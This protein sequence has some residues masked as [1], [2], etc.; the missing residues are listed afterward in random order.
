MATAFT[1][2]RLDSYKGDAPGDVSGQQK[3]AA[4]DPSAKFVPPSLDSYKGDAPEDKTARSHVSA[5]VEGL[6]TAPILPQNWGGVGKGLLE[7]IQHP[8]DTAFQGH[9]Q[10][11]DRSLKAFK[12]GDPVQGVFHEGLS[13]I[14]YI[15]PVIDQYY[16]EAKDA[17]AKGDT[18][19]E[20]RA[21]GKIVGLGTSGELARRA[22]DIIATTPKV[23][24]AVASGAGKVAEVAG[25]V[26]TGIK[27]AAPDVAGGMAMA[28]AGEALAQVPGME[29][30]ARIGMGY[31]AARLVASGVKK[32]VAATFANLAAK[33][34]LAAEAVANA[35][36]AAQDAAMAIKGVPA[37]EPE[38]TS[39]A[40]PEVIPPERQLAAPSAPPPIVA[41]PITPTPIENP[42]A[43][44]QTNWPEPPQAAGPENTANAEP[45]ESAPKELVSLDQIA[46]SMGPKVKSF[47]DLSEQQQA[48]ARQVYEEIHADHTYVRPAAP[49]PEPSATSPQPA[50]VASTTPDNG[51]SAPSGE[52]PASDIAVPASNGSVDTSEVPR[53]TPQEQPTTNPEP[54]SRV[55]EVLMA[56]K[57][58][59]SKLMSEEGL[60]KYAQDNGISEDQARQQLTGDGYQV[61][62]R[63]ALNR[64]LH[65]IGTELDMD[66]DMLSD[67]AKIQF[68]VKSM[69]QLSQE[70]MLELYQNLQ[71]KRAV[72]NP[73]LGKGELSNKFSGSKTD[74]PT[75]YTGAAQ[76]GPPSMP[77]RRPV[78]F[79]EL[80]SQISRDLAK[81]SP[82]A[83]APA[84]ALKEELDKSAGESS[85]S[86]NTEPPKSFPLIN[87]GDVVR[88][89]SGRMLK[90][91]AL[92]PNG[93]IVY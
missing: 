1:P 52:A 54:A 10:A 83:V 75:S 63:S 13:L 21:L 4:S 53:Q 33:R 20:W 24:N 9:E 28:G 82:Q 15:G 32:G 7:T 58:G 17:Q 65:G 30:P 34:A 48:M 72:N 11:V 50:P 41:G 68:R 70:Q 45:A 26:G 74:Q 62:G 66:H 3:P 25:S 42:P 73:M 64:A 19:A 84:Q 59:P 69:T 38:A 27:A 86:A 92:K 93:E 85:S 56:G 36:K 23:A 35:Q 6:K 14:P 37:A 78:G 5:F 22:P 49:A 39:P 90:V 91:K 77:S 57:I 55:V 79:D 31:P 88:L 71:E 12:S 40:A 46:Q 87:V 16:Q 47:N 67:A 8:L 61:L 80:N 51:G 60:T 29:W 18:V 81:R 43:T 76:V 2:P 89:K 44:P